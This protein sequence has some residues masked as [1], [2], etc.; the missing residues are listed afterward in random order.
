MGRSSPS[1]GLNDLTMSMTSY[2]CSC[3]NLYLPLFNLAF[4]HPWVLITLLRFSDRS[5]NFGFRT[6]R[7]TSP[8]CGD[9]VVSW[10][11]IS[12]L[13][14]GQAR[15]NSFLHHRVF[16]TSHL[17]WCASAMSTYCPEFAP[18]S[19]STH[20]TLNFCRS[21][22]QLLLNVSSSTVSLSFEALSHSLP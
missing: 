15:F 16:L 13:T 14:L 6:R 21:E 19:S 1:S 3:Q 9:Y 4:K 22:L 20:C 8:F 7:N 10:F 17:H 11:T 12:C 5:H 2:I 18:L